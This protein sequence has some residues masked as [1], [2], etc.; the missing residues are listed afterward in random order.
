MRVSILGPTN[1]VK[2]ASILQVPQKEIEQKGQEIG[3]ALADGKHQV[4]VVFNYAG[5]LKLI[6]DSC[7]K[8][9]G[10]V[11]MLYTTNDYDW[12]TKGYLP[13]L[14]EA[15]KTTE[16]PSWHDMLLS[17]VRET[18]V[19]LCAGLSAGVFAELAYMKWDHQESK[20]HVKALLGIKELLRGGRFPPEMSKDLAGLIRIVPCAK[21][22][23][24][25]DALR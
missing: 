21:L 5:M 2:F 24:A 4:R 16:S 3:K 9:G 10:Q 19:V 22:K 13:F 1:L 8:Q 23:A 11:E 7:Q 15:Q 14:K 12:D 18:D 25:L 20:G 17:L 6:G